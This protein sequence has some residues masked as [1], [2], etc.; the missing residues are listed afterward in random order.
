MTLTRVKGIM[1]DSY[2]EIGMED[3]RIKGADK[4]KPSADFVTLGE[5][6]VLLI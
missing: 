5:Y 6:G 2:E 4:I 1:S 3:D